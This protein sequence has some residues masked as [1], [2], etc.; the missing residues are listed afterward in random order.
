MNSPHIA[1]ADLARQLSRMLTPAMD[2][3]AAET[4]APAH[5]FTLAITGPEGVHHQV[6]GID[7][8]QLDALARLIQRGRIDADRFVPG[9][10]REGVC[11]HCEHRAV[12][13]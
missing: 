13:N 8:D 2:A 3:P 4:P 5:P 9:H 12:Q 6:V 10:P 11:A 7:A 1:A